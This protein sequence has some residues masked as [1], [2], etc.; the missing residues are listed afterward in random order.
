MGPAMSA[1][2]RSS[3]SLVFILLLSMISLPS[4]MADDHYDYQDIGDPN[5]VQ[6]QEMQ[7]VWDS[8]YEHTRVTWRN[9]GGDG[10]T[11]GG[12]SSSTIQN[13]PLVKY[14]VYRAAQPINA[15][16]ITDGNYSYFTEVDACLPEQDA[17]SCLDQERSAIFL[18]PHSSNGSYHYAVTT[19]LSDGTELGLVEMNVSQNYEPVIENSNPISTPF[20][21]RAT[22]DGAASETVLEWDNTVP[23]FF[24]GQLTE[25]GLNA[26]TIK[27]YEHPV[28]ATRTNWADLNP[29]LVA[30]DLPAGTNSHRLPVPQGTDREVYYTATLVDMG[31]EDFRMLTS[32]SLSEPVREDNRAPSPAFEVAASF[33]ADPSTGFGTTRVVWTDDPYEDGNETYNIWRSAT[34]FSQNVSGATLVGTSPAGVELFDVQIDQGTLG[35]S[36]Y[37][38][39]IADWVNNHDGLVSSGSTSTLIFEDTFNPWIAEPTGVSAS[40]MNGITSI[41]WNDQMGAEGEVYHVYRS[42]GARLTSASNLTLEAELVATVPDGVQS[43]TFAVTPGVVQTSYYCVTTE[44]R[45]G[46]VNGTYEDTRFVQNCSEPTLEDTRMPNPAFVSEP[47]LEVMS[48]QKYV[49]V[50]WINNIDESGETYSIWAHS[51]NPWGIEDWEEE[52]VL[53][54]NV[55]IGNDWV[56]LMDDIEEPENGMT[57]IYRNINIDVGLDQYQWYAV[58]TTDEWGNENLAISSPGNVWLVHEDTT[59]PTA[60]I[61][62]EGEDEEGNDFIAKAL[63]QGDYQLLFKVNEMLSEDPVINVTTTDYDQ[64]AG[65]GFAFTEQGG[66]VRAEPV[67]GR[68]LTYRLRMTLPAGLTNAE[69]HVEYTLVDQAGNTET[70]V[71]VGWPLDVQDPDIQMYSPGTSSTY[72]YGEYVRVHGSVSDDVGVEFVRIKFEKGLA[73]STIVLT[74]WFNVT[75]ITALDDDG[76]V[77]VFEYVDPA[78]SW[79]DKGPQKLI[80]Q[81]GDAAGNIREISIIFTVDLCQRTVSGFTVCATS[82]DDLNPPDAD[83]DGVRDDMDMCIEPTQEEVDESTGCASPGLFSGTYLLVYAMG[84]LNLVLLI[85]A[86]LAASM[87][88]ANPTKKRRGDE[89]DMLDED[90]WMADFMSGGS[91]Q[92]SPDD[93][94]ADMASLNASSDEKEKEEEK[95]VDEEEDIFQEKVSRPKRRTKKKTSDDDG[96]DDEEEGSSRPRVRRRNVRRRS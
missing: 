9:I 78:A 11:L 65:T 39:T 38:V 61:T 29:S 48:S 41:T 25:T 19:V 37:A 18:T 87:A 58:T 90:D 77:F 36:Y 31:Y 74:E 56:L 71:V 86:I 62:V 54:S 84:G 70:N 15:S 43:T 27:I 17:F 33:S 26:Y 2:S 23:V 28:P 4:A 5:D 68:E 73:Q 24:P 57:T 32:N 30:M 69:L 47:Q 51:G 82:V 20:N 13:L 52:D 1:K 83:R 22:Y 44:A 89:E 80:V 16:D 21:L 88:N 49:L 45:Y 63:T 59:P 53:T 46:Y 81:A 72:L 85:A 79:P 94:R 42:V 12:I 6:A 75:D 64:V 66:M 60:E 92:G 96:G 10:G 7:A 34:P 3:F 55:S 14:R 50:S 8:T 93:V 95:Q 35:E 67:P 76:K 40:Y 91:G